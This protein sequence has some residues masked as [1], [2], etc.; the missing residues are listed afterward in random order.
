MNTL[1]PD[2][3]LPT[4]MNILCL[5]WKGKQ[6][7]WLDLAKP[8]VQSVC[9]MHNLQSSPSAIA[10]CA[11]YINR[12]IYSHSTQ[13]CLPFSGARRSLESFVFLYFS[14]GNYFV[15]DFQ[16]LEAIHGKLVQIQNLS[17]EMWYTVMGKDRGSVLSS[18]WTSTKCLACPRRIEAT[19]SFF[20][21]R[22][23]IGISGAE[24]FQ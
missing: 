4:S 5:C 22:V 14:N 7:K 10:A 16:V 15:K 19:N 12:H 21:L 1:P 2:T 3:S 11:V 20:I 18:F 6:G 24:D 17:L 13:E 23:F 8:E 9:E